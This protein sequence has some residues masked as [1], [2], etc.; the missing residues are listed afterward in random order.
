M[1]Q[2][3]S[4]QSWFADAHFKYNGYS[5]MISY[6]YKTAPD[7]S[8][9]AADAGGSVTEAFYTGSAFNWQSGYVFKNNIQL[10]LRYTNV[11]PEAATQR[12]KDNQYT[13][14]FSKYFVGHNLKIQSDITY[15]DQLGAAGEMMY[16][17][18]VELAF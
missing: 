7:G 9:L 6:A 17:F 10:G 8:V 18:Q 3:R 14:A 11:T 5:S 15:I 13:A 16:R 1:S 4:L 12:A 2:K